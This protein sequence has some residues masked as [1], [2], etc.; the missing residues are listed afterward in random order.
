MIGR[1]IWMTERQTSGW[2][3]NQSFA[4][5]R[6]CDSVQIPSNSSETLKSPSP[7]QTQNNKAALLPPSS[8]ESIQLCFLDTARR[9]SVTYAFVSATGTATCNQ[10]MKS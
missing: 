2:G 10:A 7:Q 8:K 5:D 1:L 4:L 3:V 6:R 9:L